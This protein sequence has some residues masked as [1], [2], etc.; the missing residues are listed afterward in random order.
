M[1]CS[2]RRTYRPMLRLVLA[3]ALSFLPVAPVSADDSLPSVAPKDGLAGV[4]LDRAGRALADVTIRLVPIGPESAEIIRTKSDKAGRFLIGGLGDGAY[5]VVASKGGYSVLIGKVDTLLQASLELILHP[6]GQASALGTRPLDAAWALRLPARD[7]L[8][9]SDFEIDDRFVR[10]PKQ[11]KVRALPASFHFAATQTGADGGGPE[12]SFGVDTAI[13]GGVS[14]GRFGR[15]EAAFRHAGGTNDAPGWSEAADA[16]DLAWSPE[17]KNEQGEL[18]VE[19]RGR[20]S[21][22][23]RH[24]AGEAPGSVRSRAAAAEM[25]VAYRRV[26]GES[27]WSARASL[28]SLDAG[29]ESTFGPYAGQD[30][31]AGRANLEFEGSR[32]WGTDKHVSVRASVYGARGARMAGVGQGVLAASAREGLAD[33]GTVDGSGFDLEVANAWAPSDGTGVRAALRLGRR[34][35]F[36]RQ[37]RSAAMLEAVQK[38]DDA[39]S[40][41]ASFGL[42]GGGES[43]GRLAWA[44][45]IRRAGAR[46]DWS[47]AHSSESGLANWDD[48]G[49]LLA[50]LSR[51]L[52]TDLEG[53]IGR[54][55]AGVTYRPGDRLPVLKLSLERIDI[56]GRLVLRL[57]R[58]L[59]I[60]AVDSGGR[61]VGQTVECSLHSPR[62]GTTLG[63]RWTRVLDVGAGGILLGGAGGWV[64]QG[65]DLRQSLGRP[66]LGATAWQIVLGYEENQTT[67][68]A[69]SSAPAEVGR[70]VMLEQ[71]RISG[72]LAVAF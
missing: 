66:P 23:G 17:R 54:W 46:L 21:D 34:G 9:Q 59:P 25:N 52:L 4:T 10:E 6:A 30:L 64:R 55:I 18:R 14:I 68:V 58:D 61:G 47:I 7:I 2:K 5:R 49:D 67:D 19:V 57:P 11:E 3:A 32:P 20:R 43:S 48:G 22:R 56:D 50:P 62:T 39:L 37:V 36:D 13:S 69:E 60:V 8:E 29:Q 15:F 24:A 51:H 16:L 28:A 27:W 44:T 53:R 65:I 72:G 71:R 70:I 63:Y 40:V 38:L 12:S 26:Q 45:A 31:S 1:F 42:I 41:H 33:L 35:A